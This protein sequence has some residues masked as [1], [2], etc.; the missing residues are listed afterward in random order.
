MG[1]YVGLKEFKVNKFYKHKRY[2][3]LFL[4]ITDHGDYQSYNEK[5]GCY[6]VFSMNIDYLNDEY[7]ECDRYDPDNKQLMYFKQT[8]GKKISEIIESINE[9]K[10]STVALNL[11]DKEETLTEITD[12]L[13]AMIES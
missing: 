8:Q 3:G 4:R 9:V 7:I 13:N 11:Q 1:L 2:S 5:E 10:E 12:F 6:E